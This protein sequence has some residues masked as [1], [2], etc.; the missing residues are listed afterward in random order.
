MRV[1]R[2]AI[3]LGLMC[4]ALLTAAVGATARAHV[5]A[6]GKSN[7]VQWVAGFGAGE[8]PLTIKVRALIVDGRVKEYVLGSAHEVTERLFVVRRAFRVNDSLPGESVARWQWQRGGWLLVDRLTGRVSAINLPE[9]DAYYSAASWYRDYV[10]YC[11]VADD[12]KKTYAMVAQLSRRKPVLKKEVSGLS[13]TSGG[14]VEDAAPDS[15]CPAPTWERGPVRVSFE[16]A[17]GVRQTFAIRGHVVD[18]VNDAEEDEE[19]EK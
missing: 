2:T 3:V 17:G 11:G 12:G 16:P 18:L 19:G 14:V 9:F 6:F 10:A 7:S 5:I 8:K 13:G 4:M 1:L 15:A